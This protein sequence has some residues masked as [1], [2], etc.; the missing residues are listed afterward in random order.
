MREGIEREREGDRGRDRGRQGKRGIELY[1]GGT[2]R[3]SGITV[4]PPA[5]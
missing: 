5:S 2:E 4:F 1:T 3:Y